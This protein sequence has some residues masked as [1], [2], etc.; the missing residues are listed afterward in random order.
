MA[1]VGEAGGTTLTVGDASGVAVTWVIEGNGD[2]VAE[3]LSG[4]DKFS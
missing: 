4:A 1:G 2:G 3:A